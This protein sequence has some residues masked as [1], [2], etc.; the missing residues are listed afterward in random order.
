MKL[1]RRGFLHLAA[2]AAAL[3]AAPRI[4]GAA[5]PNV[6]HQ[7]GRVSSG[8][9]S[10]F[11][12]SFGAKGRIPMVLTHGAT[13]FDSYDW[14]G[15]AGALASD[16]EVVAFHRR[17]WGESSWSP[18]K[19]YSLAAHVSDALAV[20]GK[21]GWDQAICMGHSAGTRTAIALAAHSP[22]KA[23]GLIV[24]DQI[25]GP[26]PDGGRT[27]GNP[28]TIFPSI[29]A[30]MAN[31]AKLNNPPRIAHDRERAENA[32]VKVATGYRLKRD[33]D[34]GNTKPIGEGALMLQLAPGDLWNQLAAVK[35]PTMV[36]RGLRSD[37][38][39]NPAILE[40][41][42]R[43]YPQVLVATIDSRH[44]I[45][46]EAPEALIAHVRKFVATM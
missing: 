9:V 15:I 41:L 45:L 17:G 27:I 14:I 7:T 16:R 6:P 20:I 42:T 34:S 21:M 10:I 36:V 4:A 13:Y 19:D 12:R 30:A 2:G 3:A 37:R 43:E 29:E 23:A 44:D 38:W 8:D 5:L 18:S 40:R 26:P 1:P 33:P 11:Y 28:P 25:E 22:A 31:F 32:L 24:I 35:A 39:D 46:D